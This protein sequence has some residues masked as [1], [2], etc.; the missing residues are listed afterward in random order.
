MRDFK[1]EGAKEVD[2]GSRSSKPAKPILDA[3]ALVPVYRAGDGDVR[4]VLVRRSE[5][6]VHGGHLS[7]LGGK[8]DPK[9]ACNAMFQPCWSAVFRSGMSAP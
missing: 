5:G 1:R 2:A 3:A 6:G 8:H 9:D 7:F 4:I